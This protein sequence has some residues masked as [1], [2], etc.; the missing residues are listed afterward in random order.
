MNNPENL[1]YAESHEWLK[2]EGKEG[3]LTFRKLAT[4]SRKVRKWALLNQ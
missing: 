3:V 4:A 2:V 1:L